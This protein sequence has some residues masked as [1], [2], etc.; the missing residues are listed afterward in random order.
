M[1]NK[2]ALKLLVVA[3]VIACAYALS[4]TFVSRSVEKKADKYAA[5]FDV[6]QQDYVRENYL[7]SMRTQD[8][9]NLGFIKFTYKEVKE[10]E[11]NLG[12]DLKGGMNV[13]LE[14]SPVDIV[15]A[16]SNNNQDPIFLQALDQASA[17]QAGGSTD[18]IGD[19]V[20]A[21]EGLSGGSRLID[22]FSTSDLSTSKELSLT[23]TNQQVAEYLRHQ[24]ESAIDNSYNILSKRIDRFGI[25]QPNIQRVKNTGRILVELPGIKEPERVRKLLQGA[26]ALE[27]WMT[28]DQSAVMP[29]IAQADRAIY[30]IEKAKGTLAGATE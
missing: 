17:A 5:G 24:V 10:K 21:Y 13:L 4:F 26:A 25:A 12:L 7:D 28:Y 30:D 11:I 22:V 8:V 2:G 23:A 6:E 15:K 1:Q 27:F 19:F 3:L 16:L 20:S 29:Y 9:Y 18:F 14:I